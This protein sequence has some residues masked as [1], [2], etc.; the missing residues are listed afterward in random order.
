MERIKEER[1]QKERKQRIEIGY[2]MN[3]E[4]DREKESRRGK[5]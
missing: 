3:K 5:T 2:E 1:N 4:K